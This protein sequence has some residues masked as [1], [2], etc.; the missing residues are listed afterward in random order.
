MFIFYKKK[1]K[2][3]SPWT[4]IISDAILK[5]NDNGQLVELYLKWWRNNEKLNCDLYEQ[6]SLHT[7][8]LTF[9]GE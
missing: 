6:K 8:S 3:D 4:N 9:N 7:Q 1:K 5:L 2:K